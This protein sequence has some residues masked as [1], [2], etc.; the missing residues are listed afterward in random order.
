MSLLLLS[1][2]ALIS[3]AITKKKEKENLDVELK[4]K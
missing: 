2:G 3:I 4:S 1:K